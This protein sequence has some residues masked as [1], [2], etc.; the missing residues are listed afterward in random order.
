MD[1]NH[2]PSQHPEDYLCVPGSGSTSLF[3]TILPNET[4]D[5]DVEA[6]TLHPKP[7]E[8]ENCTQVDDPVFVD[9]SRPPG[10][11]SPSLLVEMVCRGSFYDEFYGRADDSFSR[12]RPHH[13]SESSC[14]TC[15]ALCTS[16][17]SRS[18]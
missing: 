10:V 14:L 8:L 5:Q 16:D 1:E 12:L 17:F 18:A 13:K 15:R 9:D 7:E 3:A 4:A 6:E 2:V 11:F